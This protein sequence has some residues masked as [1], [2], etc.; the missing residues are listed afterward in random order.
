MNSLF[1]QLWEVLYD[2]TT[3]ARRL[4]ILS[5][6]DPQ[7]IEL[8]EDKCILPVAESSYSAFSDPEKDRGP[9]IN[10]KNLNEV[11]FESHFLKH[12]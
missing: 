7:Q 5:E 9:I 10:L 6:I 12:H 3:T 4:N 8:L 2:D 1:E 11:P